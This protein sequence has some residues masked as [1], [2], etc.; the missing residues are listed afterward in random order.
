M[1]TSFYERCGSLISPGDILD[2]LLPVKLPAT[3]KFAKRWS[4]NLPARFRVQGELHDVLEI[5]NHLT[6]KD[7]NLENVEAPVLVP[8]KAGKSIFLTWGSEVEDDE[9][10]GKLE[11]KYWIVAP[12][13]PITPELQRQRI[14][15]T[16]ELISDAIRGNKSPHFFYLPSLAGD[17]SDYYVDFRKMCPV[18]AVH[19]RRVQRDWRLSV[20]A[21]N[22]FYQQLMWFFTR[23][24]IFFLPLKC[25][26]FACLFR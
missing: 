3:L 12:V 5:D 20:T 18:S 4:S 10:S 13:I 21:L 7:A 1:A 8:T 6:L 25:H 15:G 2:K 14:S 17:P 9:R 19:V 11:K 22:D 23:K 26:A 16:N 24:K